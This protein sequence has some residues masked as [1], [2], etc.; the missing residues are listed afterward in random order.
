M[1]LQVKARGTFLEWHG[2]IIGTKLMRIIEG[3]LYAFYRNVEIELTEGGWAK[4]AST[5]QDIELRIPAKN[6]G[7]YKVRSIQMKLGYHV[8]PLEKWNLAKD[9]YNAARVLVQ[10]SPRD[11]MMVGDSV[12]VCTFRILPPNEIPLIHNIEPIWRAI[13]TCPV[14][15]VITQ[16]EK[17]LELLKQVE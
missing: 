9:M 6:C 1:C 10:F 16:Q 2:S 15:A 4:P 14:Q 7:C 8:A 11:V 17:F 5:Y 12:V 13:K 3:K